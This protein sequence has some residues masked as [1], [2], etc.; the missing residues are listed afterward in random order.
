MTFRP[1][2]FI[3]FWVLYPASDE[4]SLGVQVLILTTCGWYR[5]ERVGAVQKTGESTRDRW[6]NTD[7]KKVAKD[8]KSIGF[9]RED[10]I[11]LHDAE[12]HAE[13]VFDEVLRKVRDREDGG[14]ERGLPIV[15]NCW[16]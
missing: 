7:W 6:H 16:S 2:R 10:W 13:E 14:A 8:P 4:N 5:Y 3:P 12:R 1:F 9:P 15:G 11:H